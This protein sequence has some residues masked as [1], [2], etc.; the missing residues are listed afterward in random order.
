MKDIIE[1]LQEASLYAGRAS[2]GA[3]I[4]RAIARIKELEA[5]IAGRRMCLNCGRYAPTGHDRDQ[6]LSE[7]VDPETGLSAC[8]FDLTPDE[9]WAHWSKIVH[10]GHARIA[11]LEAALSEIKA[12][13]SDPRAVERATEALDARDAL[14]RHGTSK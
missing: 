1:E 4:E 10:I 13:S 7:C 9:A 5:E 6:P 11:A 2:V 12:L 14:A 8:T 3:T